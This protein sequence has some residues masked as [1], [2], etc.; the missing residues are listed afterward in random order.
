[1]SRNTNLHS[2]TTVAE[3]ENGYW[4]AKDLKAFAKH[5]GVANSSSLRKDELETIIKHYLQ[6]GT[7]P[8]QQTPQRA[9]KPSKGERD[10]LDINTRVISYVSD[11]KTKTF[12][13]EQAQ[14][15]CP[16]L[17]KKSGVWY[18]TNRWREEQLA[19]KQ[20]ITYLQL[21][22]HFVQLSTQEGRLPQIP[23][24]RFN[25]FITDFL[26]AGEGNREEAKAAWEDLK[27][28]DIPK[29]YAAWKER[30]T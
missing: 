3:F 7:L 25:N 2:I 5:I 8:Q 4:Y 22:K 19:N 26:A 12:I 24:A 17:P 27:S 10:T 28:L 18:W 16:N 29:T 30:E 1:M 23:S 15:L 21:V 9:K 13:L 14:T 6:S 20:P 11:K